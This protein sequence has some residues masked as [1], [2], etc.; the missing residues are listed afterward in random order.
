MNI[1]PP[2]LTPRL[3][4]AAEMAGKCEC[5]ADIGT[6]HAYLPIYLYMTGKCKTAIASDIGKGPLERARQ[7]AQR[8]NADISLRLGGGLDT[9]KADEA[10]CVVIAGMGGLLIAE[11]LKNGTDKLNKAKK[12]ILQPMTA[13]PELRYFLID[14]GWTIAEERL[15]KENNKLYVLMS[16]KRPEADVKYK[17]YTEAELFLGK[18]LIENKPKFYDEYFKRRLN[19]LEKMTEGLKNSESSESE[20]KLALINKLIDEIKN[21][22]GEI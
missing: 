7:T 12:I 21:L 3:A 19:K 10:D 6:D 14:N 22:N 1:T 18:Y 15:A 13:V 8:Y 17:P 2:V 16:V 9:L 20:K 4:A 11:I 5:F